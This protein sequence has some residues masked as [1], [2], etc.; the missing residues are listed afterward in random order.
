MKNI[1]KLNSG[2]KSGD[3]I[4]VSALQN[5]AVCTAPEARTETCAKSIL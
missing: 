2:V 5:G 4:K 1:E 3:P